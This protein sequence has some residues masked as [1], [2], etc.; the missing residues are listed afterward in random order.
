MPINSATT[1]LPMIVH[2]INYLRTFVSRAFL[3][4]RATAEVGH[5]GLT[6]VC[7]GV[8][9]QKESVMKARYE[10]LEHPVIEFSSWP[11]RSEKGQERK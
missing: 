10:Q 5:G 8:P 1:L 2:A 3:N 4:G 7:R 9:F 6:A 11:Q